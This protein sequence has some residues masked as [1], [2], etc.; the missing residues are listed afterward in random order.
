MTMAEQDKTP[1]D[2]R[3]DKQDVDDTLDDTFP[4]SDPP[5][6]TGNPP[7]DGEK[8]KKDEKDK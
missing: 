2:I 5:A 7:G 1:K 4:A 3:E 8:D 6:W